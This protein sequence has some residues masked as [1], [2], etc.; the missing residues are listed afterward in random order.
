MGMLMDNAIVVIDE[1]ER[2]M[3]EGSNLREAILECCQFLAIPLIG[4]TLTTVFSFAPIALM[5]GSTGEFVGTIAI[6][7]IL[8][9]LISIIFSLTVVPAFASFL[10]I[11]HVTKHNPLLNPFHIPERLLR[12]TLGW[13]LQYPRLGTLITLIV[14]TFGF[15][16]Q[17]YLEEQFFPPADRDQFQIQLELAANA[18]IEET[19]A[20]AREIRKVAL[21]DPRI[22]EVHWF[23]GESAPAFYYNIVPDKSNLPNFGQALVKCRTSLEARGAIETLQAIVTE[24]FPQAHCVVRQLEQ[25]PPF[26]APIEILVLGDN[27]QQLK[28]LGDDIRLVLSQTPKITHTLVRRCKRSFPKRLSKSTIKLLILLGM[29]QRL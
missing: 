25:G 5:P 15:L 20:L 10:L 8:A 2:K 1:I 17:P 23:L 11:G 21:H 6:S 26:S 24:Q 7:T 22:E 4:S 29:I 14:P 18:S 16:L 27:L 12:S 28:Q 3:K 9:V 19:E 13:M